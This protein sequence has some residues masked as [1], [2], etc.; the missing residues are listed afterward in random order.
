MA[1]RVSDLVSNP[2]HGGPV[3]GASVGEAGSPDRLLVRIGLWVEPGRL[4]RARFRAT[5]CAALIAY[6]EAACAAVESGAPPSRLGG[7][8]IRALV[9]GVHPLHRG[10]A[11]L[12]A[13]A[14]RAAAAAAHDL[15]ADT[16][17]GAT[18]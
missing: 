5:A 8:S 9:D 18:P 13:A 10:R 6:A 4:P 2:V 11:D 15:A 3:D 16:A 12:V 17:K 7:P 1:A 14:L